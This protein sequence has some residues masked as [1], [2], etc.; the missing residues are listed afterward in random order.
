[1]QSENTCLFK[2]SNRNPKTMYE[3]CLKVTVDI[4]RNYRSCSDV[5]VFILLFHTYFLGFYFWHWTGKCH[6][7]NWVLTHFFLIS[8][9]AVTHYKRETNATV[10]NHKAS[11]LKHAPDWV[12]G[13]CHKGKPSSNNS[14]QEEDL[15]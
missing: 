10:R 13:G 8:D 14:N 2:V 7:G 1:M 6:L 3:I 4:W 15:E 5:F 12:D 9:A 11:S